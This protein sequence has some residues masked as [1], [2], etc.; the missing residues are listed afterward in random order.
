MSNVAIKI[1]DDIKKLA[2]AQAAAAGY[3]NVEDYVGALIVADANPVSADLESHL[4]AALQSPSRE[5]S[6]AD[7]DE[8]RRALAG[9]GD[10]G[11]R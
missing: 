11:E 1:P 3:T 8:K 10:A 4:V 7:W 9:G 6:A 5:M 2:D